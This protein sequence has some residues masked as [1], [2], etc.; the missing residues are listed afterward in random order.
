MKGIKSV[1]SV[2]AI[3]VKYGAYVS[4][5]IAAIQFFMNEVEKIESTKTEKE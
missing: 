2:L 3:V 1:L 4:A 5:L